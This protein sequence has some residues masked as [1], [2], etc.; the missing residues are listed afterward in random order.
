VLLMEMEVGKA[1]P[2][3]WLRD[4]GREREGE[5]E[6]GR[7]RG[8]ER[9]GEGERGREREREGERSENR[10]IVIEHPRKKKLTLRHLDF[11]VVPNTSNGLSDELVTSVS[12]KQK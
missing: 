12:E 5:G 8:R 1:R 4:R 6:R 2:G 7:E 11:L 9:E 3:I 10:F